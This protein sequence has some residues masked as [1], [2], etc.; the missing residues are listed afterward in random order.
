MVSSIRH[1]AG[2]L[3]GYEKGC[4]RS[5]KGCSNGGCHAKEVTEKDCR[6]AVLNGMVIKFNQNLIME[7]KMIY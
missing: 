3:G 2:L 6:V 7:S 5:C 1:G 4:Y